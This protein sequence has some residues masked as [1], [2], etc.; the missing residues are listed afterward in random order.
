MS[1][2]EVVFMSIIGGLAATMILVVTAEVL[3]FTPEDD[4]EM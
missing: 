3:G 1:P 2:F 4:D